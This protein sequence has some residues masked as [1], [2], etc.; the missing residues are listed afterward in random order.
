MTRLIFS[1][2]T[3]DRLN[4]RKRLAI[5]STSSSS[6]SSWTCVL[7]LPILGANVLGARLSGRAN[8]FALCTVK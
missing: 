5:L 8:V 6:S 1:R 2:S 4:E 3:F 7:Y